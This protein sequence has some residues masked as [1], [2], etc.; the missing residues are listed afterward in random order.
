VN[1]Q[2]VSYAVD[3]EQ[4]VAV[5]ATGNSPWSFR[6]GGAVVVFGLADKRCTVCNRSCFFAGC[7]GV[8]RTR[9]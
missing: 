9:A 2:P 6:Q 8:Q 1:A 7:H 4:Y 5:A 3:S